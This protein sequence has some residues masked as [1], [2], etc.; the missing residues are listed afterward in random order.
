ML[1][2]RWEDMKS[3]RILFSLLPLSLAASLCASPLPAGEG[4]APAPQAA[5]TAGVQSDAFALQAFQHLLKEQKGNVVFSP[6]GL[7]GALQLLQQG[8][9]GKVAEEL[10]SLPVGKREGES[11]MQVSEA[12]ALFV[13]E[14]LK[15]KPGVK[16]D[17]VIRAPFATDQ[18][19]S[20]TLINEWAD[21][22]TRG[23]I[24][25]LD[26][27][28]D[29]ETRL[30][31]ATAIALEEKWLA[32]FFPHKNSERNFHLSDGSTKKV[33]MMRKNGYFSYAEDED[34]AAVALF[35][36]TDGRPGTP[37]CFIGILPKGDARAFAAGLTP[38]KMSAIRGQLD[39]SKNQMVE[40]N[41]PKFETSTPTYSLK[42]VLQ[43]CGVHTAF[44]P[45]ADFSGFADEELVLKEVRQKCFVKVDE[46]GTKAAA[47]T[48]FGYALGAPP[49]PRPEPKVITFDRPFLWVIGDLTSPAAPW[50]MGLCE[51]P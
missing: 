10:A 2:V 18:E 25:E 27:G 19:K 28:I 35:Y 50:F 3:H 4:P 24:P 5:A 22:N 36:K 29:D 31:A 37:G 38:E 45:G 11:A 6:A 32:P 26:V 33:C 8:A 48:E 14:D 12:N 9:R 1:C 21:K 43:A 44:L 16:V 40:V 7:E 30:V 47:V 46:E 17:E 39:A 51:E 20:K 42:S 15:L 49:G 23:M 13:A 41:L 34:W